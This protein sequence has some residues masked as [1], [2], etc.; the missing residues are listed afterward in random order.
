M[1]VG[2]REALM[3]GLALVL[4]SCGNPNALTEDRISEILAKQVQLNPCIP[5]YGDGPLFVEAYVNGSAMEMQ[6]FLQNNE[7]FPVTVR[8]GGYDNFV[9]ARFQEFE[10]A[11]LLISKLESEQSGMMGGPVQYRTF[12]LTD[13]G[14][15]LYQVG[16]RRFTRDAPAHKNPLFC[17][18]KGQVAAVVNFVIPAEG[19]NTTRVTYRWN[20]VDGKGSVVSTLPNKPWAQIGSYESDRLPLEGEGTAILMLTNNGWAV[21]E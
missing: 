18:G 2:G 17:P 6:N 16:E 4:S 14:R 21:L 3:A 13:L 5:F 1:T 12:D 8:I 9:A 11:G 20:T 7:P 19:A 10:A 15:S